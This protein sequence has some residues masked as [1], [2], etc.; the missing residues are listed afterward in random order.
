MTK[1]EVWFH[2]SYFKF[3]SQEQPMLLTQYWAVLSAAVS[4]DKDQEEEKHGPES[5]YCRQTK[6]K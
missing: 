6:Q 1:V 5:T 2:C 4:L 3:P